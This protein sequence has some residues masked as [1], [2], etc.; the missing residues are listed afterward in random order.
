WALCL[1]PQT[2]QVLWK[3]ELL[4]K[5]NH[6]GGIH[7]PV[8]APVVDDDRV[9]F[10]PYDA[11][12]NDL[13][14][15]RCPVVCLKTDG[16]ELWREGEKYWCTEGST[17]LVLDDTLYV[18]SSGPDHLMVAVDKRTGQLRWGTR[19]D[20][21]EKRLFGGGS[22]VTYQEVAGIPQVIG[23]AWGTAAIYGIDA[24]NGAIM[25]TMPN[26]ATI[27]HG[28]LCTPVAVGNRLLLSA[29][30]GGIGRFCLCLELIPQDGKLKARTLYANDKIQ[31]N[32][33][34][35]PSVYQEAVFGFAGS[36]NGV[37]QCTNFDDG[38]LLWEVAGQDW[39]RDRQ[40]IIADGL[41]FA[42]TRHNELVLAEANR[43]TYR[44]LGRVALPVEL[45]I[46]PQQPMLANG[47]L[48]IRS[49]RH[50]LCYQVGAPKRFLICAPKGTRASR[51][52]TSSP[53]G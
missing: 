38:K 3:R 30:E 48:Y 35:T 34:H 47:R 25:W 13:W 28:L 44:E 46:F 24:R 12:Q 15:P 51:T 17:P 10:V 20:T 16:T 2:G 8:S 26:P 29:G 39:A 27:K 4:A 21:K 43:Q 7:G 49:D 9:Y 19:L 14:D 53:T 42:L 52:T 11:Y 1:N 33:I 45:G 5:E 31:S 36:T 37:L 23:C 32:F 41:I 50:L 22:S 40:L 18:S 6:H